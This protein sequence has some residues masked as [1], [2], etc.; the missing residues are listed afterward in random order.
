MSVTP[1]IREI[2]TVYAVPLGPAAVRNGDW[3]LVCSCSGRAGDL[4][5]LSVVLG[6]FPI[7][8]GDSVLQRK[9]VTYARV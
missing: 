3:A 4:G 5:C 1:D 6:L 9:S 8:L 7:H 2:L